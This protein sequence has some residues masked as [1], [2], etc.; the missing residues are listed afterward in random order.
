MFE[1]TK[2]SYRMCWLVILSVLFGHLS[3]FSSILTARVLTTVQR[4]NFPNLATTAPQFQSYLHALANNTM[5]ARLGTG[6]PWREPS[7]HRSG[8]PLLQRTQTGCTGRSID[9]QSQ[10]GRSKCTSK[11][12][13]L[14]KLHRGRLCWERV[15]RGIR[16]GRKTEDLMIRRSGSVFG[17]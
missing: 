9:R 5:A 13:S 4:I 17:G 1:R 8:E 3:K 16:P 10:S 2:T 11:N 15:T 14:S 6:W 7:K 12:T